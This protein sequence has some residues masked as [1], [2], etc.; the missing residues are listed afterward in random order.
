MSNNDFQERLERIKANRGEQQSASPTGQSGAQTRSVGPMVLGA[1]LISFGSTTLRQTNKHYEAIRD[2][3]G[4]GAA[5][6]LAVLGIVFLAL[7]ARSIWKWAKGREAATARAKT[8]PAAA[9]ETTSR[10]RVTKS[11][12]GLAL[13]VIAALLMFLGA[14]YNF[15][16]T[17]RSIA[18]ANLL[19]IAALLLTALV[20]MVGATGFVLRGRAL[21]RVPAC[22]F[23]GGLLTYAVV[24]AL[25]INTLAWLEYMPQGL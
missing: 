16:E 21:L 6:G 20:V 22:F 9:V 4:L 13:G 19:T 7:G 18:M 24:R 23:I 14:A 10:D 11:L 17:G 5:V 15:A 8:M 12:L 2:G 1:V 3:Y 25:R